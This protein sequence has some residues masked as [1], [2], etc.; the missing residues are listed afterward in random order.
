MDARPT[1]SLIS[2]GCPKNTV[3][4]EVLL[5]IL[6]DAGYPIVADFEE[7]DVILV[8]TCCFIRPA[9]DEAT[10]AIRQM[11]KRRK[12][13]SLRTL[14]V[15]GCLPQRYRDRDLAHIFPWV[16]AFVG[17]GD[18]PK[19][20]SVLER[21]LTNTRVSEISARPAWQYDHESPRVR[22]T[23]PHLTYV[24]I[25]EGCS[26]R[27][28]FCLI[29]RLRGR[30][31]SRRMRSVI[32]EVRWL[33]RD[34]RLRE[35]N[36]IAQDTTAYG[37]DLYGRPRLSDLLRK[38]ARENL[39]PWVRLLYAYPRSFT[40]GLIDVIASE[41]TI[42]KY[43]DLPLQHCNDELLKR[44]R[45]GTTKRRIVG[46]LERLRKRI[47]DP[48]IRTTFIVGF[49][50]ESDRQFR[51]LMDFVA[52]QKFHRLGA[53]VF[54]P[55]KGTPASQYPDQVP[56]EIKEERLHQLMVL[57][58]AISSERN[59]E[60][61][62]RVVDVLI[63]AADEDEPAV[64]RGRTEADAFEIDGSVLIPGGTT[65]PGQFARVKITGASEYDLVG[66]EL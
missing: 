4:S 43:I 40:A 38:I 52:E 46:L 19:I 36:V 20:A 63:D 13:G 34:E 47:P 12:D 32:K 9:T 61:I 18:I 54:W 33:G 45:R 64:L 53:F 57:Q 5:G 17:P 6:N 60:Q 51:E 66:K 7:A 3:D 21:C 14:V 25:A 56:D 42:C 62:G 31:R 30:Y 10:E 59:R 15:T 26:H 49:P 24:K 55:E 22:V 11:E 37:R 39:V 16:D 48:T 29:P 1:V 58:Q 65:K 28:S 41:E 50:G 23:L 8:N 44:M 35:L 27:C 2:L